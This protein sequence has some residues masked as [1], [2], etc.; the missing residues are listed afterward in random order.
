MQE[1]ASKACCS[2]PMS[3]VVSTTDGVDRAV[4]IIIY[5]VIRGDVGSTHVTQVMSMR[6]T[7]N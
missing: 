1:L 6:A 4:D 3:R 7:G 2:R 5:G